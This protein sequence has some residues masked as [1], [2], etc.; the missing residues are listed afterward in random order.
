MN[1]LSGVHK[2]DELP[3][4]EVLQST[5]NVVTERRQQQRSQFESVADTRTRSNEILITSV[6]NSR[7]CLVS[8]CTH[9]TV[10]LTK[11]NKRSVPSWIFCSLLCSVPRFSLTTCHNQSAAARREIKAD[12]RYRLL[13]SRCG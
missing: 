2:R 1:V 7:D 5:T 3:R 6:G 12:P 11:Q 9:V 10:V 13:C 8:A 4:H